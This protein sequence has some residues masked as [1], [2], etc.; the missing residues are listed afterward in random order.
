MPHMT[1]LLN[2]LS[3]VMSTPCWVRQKEAK[4]IIDTAIIDYPQPNNTVI[5]SFKELIIFDNEP[6]VMSI[7]RLKC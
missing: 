7:C 6:S 1:E 3:P 2:N 4:S 5:N